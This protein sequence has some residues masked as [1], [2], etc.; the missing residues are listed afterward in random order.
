[1]ESEKDLS[2]KMLSDIDE[3]PINTEKDKSKGNF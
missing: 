1:M 2:D 3:V